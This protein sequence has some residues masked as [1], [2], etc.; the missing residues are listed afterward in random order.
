MAISVK[1]IERLLGVTKVGFETA[2]DRPDLLA[3]LSN[4][5]YG[6][7]RMIALLNLNA[8]LETKYVFQQKKRG[9]QIIATKN[10]NEKYSAEKK[11]YRN[12]KK[13]I[14]KALRGKKYEKYAQ[15]LGLNENIKGTLDG[16]V[17]QAKQLYTN[18]KDTPEILEAGAN[19]GLTPEKMQEGLDQLEVLLQ[20]NK[21]QENAKGLAQVARDERDQVYR[22]LRTEWQDFKDVCHMAFEGTPQYT[23]IMGIVSY[24]EGYV[25]NKEENPETPAEEPQE[26]PQT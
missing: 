8:Q 12:T 3:V 13:L 15:L 1:A 6:E 11:R 4:H 21:T 25:K 9:E 14:K 26:P 18:I 22:Q 2:K 5:A 23:E 19:Y 24:S 10:M 20:L 17:K 16:F 7:P